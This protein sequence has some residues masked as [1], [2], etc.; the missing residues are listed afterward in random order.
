MY[1]ARGLIGAGIAGG[2]DDIKRVVELIEERGIRLRAASTS[3]WWSGMFD[4]Q[5]RV[6]Q[7]RADPDRGA[8]WRAW[9]M[10]AP[11]PVGR[12]ARPDAPPRDRTAAGIEVHRRAAGRDPRARAG[13]RAD[14]ADRRR[15]R[16]QDDA[17]E[18]LV[19]AWKADTRFSAKGREVIGA[20]MAW[21]Q[22][23]ALRDAGIDR[24]LRPLAAAGDDRAPASSTPAATPS[25]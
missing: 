10:R 19:D 3:R 15:R 12:A 8:S 21:R 22:A 2:P 1:A 23:D 24:D 17:P 13:R 7:H 20:A 6:S 5:V 9:P 25:W 4:G 11:R 14:P 18:P 16:R